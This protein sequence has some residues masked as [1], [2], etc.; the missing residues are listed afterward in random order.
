MP[1]Q[2]RKKTLASTI[3]IAGTL[4]STALFIWLVSRQKW[5]VVLEK[6]S[7]IAVW[8]LALALGFYLLSYG[9]NTLRWCALLWTQDVNITFWQAF[10]I[11]WA[12]RFAS[13]FLPST[14]GGDGFRMLAVHP[15]T[16]RKT[17]SI[18]SVA[19]DRIINMAAMACLLPAPFI[20]FGDT[21]MSLR[22]AFL[23]PTLAPPARAGE[24]SP[25][26]LQEIA[27]SGF[28][29]VPLRS[30]L[31]AMT[32]PISLQKLF[33]KYFPKVV[34]AFRLWASK[35]WAILYAFLAAWPS[36]LFPMTATYILAYQLGMNV[37]FWQVIGVQTVSYFLSVLPIS[38]NGYGLREVTYTTL[39]AALGASLEQASTLALVTRFVNI[40]ATIPGALWLSSAVVDVVPFEESSQT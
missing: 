36:N 6:A 32:L 35:P 9:F 2:S 5:D 18:G 30:A 24:Q 40:I 14:I 11:S 20:I 1:P 38:V 16:R 8:A 27:S 33:E 4:I 10:R 37:T 39:Y 26:H 3:R 34:S 12:E 21:L 23:A 28:D 29:F 17:I 19:L 25:L 7:G 13:N 22:G 15:Y 31:L